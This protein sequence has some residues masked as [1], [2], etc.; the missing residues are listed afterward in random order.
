MLRYAKIFSKISRVG[1]GDQDESSI[2]QVL[3]PIKRSESH[4]T[5]QNI[6]FQHD[7]QSYCNYLLKMGRMD[8]QFLSLLLI[9]ELIQ[10]AAQ[11]FF[12]YPWE[13]EN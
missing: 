1:S 8:K 12:P 7:Y 2:Q 5:Q 9:F 10:Q 11:T 13:E 4:S 6:I 3:K